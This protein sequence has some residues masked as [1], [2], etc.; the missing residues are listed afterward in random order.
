[1]TGPGPD[2]MDLE[3]ILRAGLRVPDHGK[4][5]PW[6]FLVFQ[7]DAR[8]RFGEVLKGAFLKQEPAADAERIEFER[9]RFL[10]APVVVAVISEARPHAKIPEWEQVLSCGAACQN[11]VVA[12]TA[13]GHAAQWL[14]EWYAYDHDV[15][16]ALGLRGGERVAGFLYFGT[17]TAKP[18]ERA[19]PEFADKVANWTG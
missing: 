8:E 5:A 6:R 17:P 18:S 1:M 4:L 2:A 10:R 11:M 12:A 15:S 16:S 3:T 14:T 7:G 9:A 19:R 13:M